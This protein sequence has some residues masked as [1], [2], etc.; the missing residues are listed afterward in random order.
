M[1]H[2]RFEKGP[3]HGPVGIGLGENERNFL[4]DKKRGRPQSVLSGSPEKD[5]TGLAF[6]AKK[7][8]APFGG[9]FRIDQTIFSLY[10]IYMENI[11]YIYLLKHYGLGLLWILV[12][13]GALRLILDI[14]AKKMVK[15]VVK[16]GISKKPL[17]EQRIKTVWNLLLTLGSLIIYFILLLMVLNLF[18]VNIKPVLTGVGIIGIVVGFGAQSIIKDFFAGVLMLFEN[19][20]NIGDKV[21]IGDSSGIVA[22]MTFRSTILRDGSGR[23]HHIANGSI[24]NVV[25]MSQKKTKGGK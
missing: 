10:L 11:D 18:G 6:K 22:K 15:V 21:K 7:N 23:L 9:R 1:F 25:N 8:A 16:M 13:F 4:S 19:Q 2:P 3:S 24:T 14:V 17:L 12:V 5:L 20:Y